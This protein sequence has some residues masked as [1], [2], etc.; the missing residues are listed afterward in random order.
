M[1]TTDAPDRGAETEWTVYYDSMLLLSQLGQG[2]SW[3]RCCW[4]SIGCN[5]KAGYGFDS[6]AGD[7]KAGA[8]RGGPI[9]ILLVSE[10]LT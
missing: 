6:S 10:L 8:E 1:C 2:T 9:V 4:D 5:E 7:P 3:H